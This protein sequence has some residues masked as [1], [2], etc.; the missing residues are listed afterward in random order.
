MQGRDAQS[1]FRRFLE[2]DGGGFEDVVHL[3]K[4]N[5]IY[6]I[7]R[8]VRDVPLAEDLAAEAFAQLYIHKKRYNFKVSLKTYLFT[9][10]RNLAVSAIRKN[11]R[12]LFVEQPVC[13]ETVTLEETVLKKERDRQL[14]AAMHTLKPDYQTVLHLLY[15]EELSY[16][17]CARVLHKNKKQID[18]LAYRAKRSLKAILEKEGFDYEIV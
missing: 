8:Y 11:A 9:I 4:D 5:L 16:E 10:G 6:F 7:N 17:E 1:C 3:Y 14:S 12:L 15:F 2:G 13:G 18:N